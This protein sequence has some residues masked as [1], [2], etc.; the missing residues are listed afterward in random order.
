MIE[1]IDYRRYQLVSHKKGKKHQVAIIQIKKVVVC[2]T[3]KRNI[4]KWSFDCGVI[5]SLTE[6][7][8]RVIL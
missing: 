6:V 2:N 4:F 1:C 3:K 5:P 8:S 7:L